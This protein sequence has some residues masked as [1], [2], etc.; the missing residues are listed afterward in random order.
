MMAN[1]TLLH[2]ILDQPVRIVQRIELNG[3]SMRI[4]LAKSPARCIK[5]H[6]IT[7]TESLG[8]ACDY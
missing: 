6:L 1:P 4:Q 2:A 8:A 3:E 7:L 5:I